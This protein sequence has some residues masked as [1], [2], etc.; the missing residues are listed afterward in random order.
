MRLSLRKAMSETRCISSCRDGRLAYKDS[1]DSPA[2]IAVIDT[3]QCFG[4]MA[5]TGKTLRAATIKAEGELHTLWIDAHS[6][7]EMLGRHRICN[8]T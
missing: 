6:F 2:L 3:G 7:A 4:E 1:G 8:G 5:I